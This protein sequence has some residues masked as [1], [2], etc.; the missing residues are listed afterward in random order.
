MGVKGL[1][2]LIK[3][4]CREV[5]AGGGNGESLDS[6]LEGQRRVV[7]VIDAMC[8]YVPSQKSGLALDQMS[9]GGRSPCP[10]VLDNFRTRIQA[11]LDGAPQA[12]LVVVFDGDKF[13]P[14]SATNDARIAHREKARAKL[15]AL[16][17][18]LEG[19]EV[20]D[21]IRTDILRLRRDCVYKRSDL[22]K[23]LVSW[24]NNQD[25][26]VA[27]QS[28]FEADAQVVYLERLF[29]AQGFAAYSVGIDSDIFAYGSDHFCIYAHKGCN[30]KYFN[31]VQ[32]QVVFQSHSFKHML[33]YPFNLFCALLGNDF[34]PNPTGVGQ[35]SLEK[36]FSTH[37]ADGY[38][39][40]NL[41]LKVLE[42]TREHLLQKK[43]LPLAEVEEYE[44]LVNR[45]V[46]IFACYPVFL[47]KPES[48][49]LF[50]C[51]KNGDIT[52]DIGTH[53]GTYGIDDEL[54]DLLQLNSW[55]DKVFVYMES[56]GADRAVF[57]KIFQADLEAT[58]FAPF[59]ESD[60][61]P[62]VTLGNLGQLPNSVLVLWL[63][64]RGIPLTQANAQNRDALLQIV[65]NALRIEQ[66]YA[67]T[68]HEPFTVRDPSELRV[69]EYT[70]VQVWK[71]VQKQPEWQSADAVCQF[72]VDSC[73]P[74]TFEFLQ[75]A[76]PDKY[77]RATYLYNNGHNL[78]KRSALALANRY[79]GRNR[80]D[81]TLTLV[82]IPVIPSF[83]SPAYSC[84]LCF[85]SNGC[86]KG[87]PFSKCSCKVGALE[88]AHVISSLMLFEFIRSFFLTNGGPVTLERLPLRRSVI[89]LQSDVLLAEFI[90]DFTNRSITQASLEDNQ[91]TTRY[92]QLYPYEDNDGDTDGSEADTDDTS[93]SEGE[94][95]FERYLQEGIRRD[96]KAAANFAK[97]RWY[98]L[99]FNQWNSLEKQKAREVLKKW[100]V[101]LS[102][103]EEEHF[104]SLPFLQAYLKHE[105][106][107]SDI[108][109]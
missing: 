19:I 103:F 34:C 4:V 73:Q 93:T 8:L 54:I 31:Y 107:K 100:A 80:C 68:D 98:Q 66:Q 41:S 24:C 74:P 13:P 95:E 38:E 43:K 28:P 62:Q 56:P 1:S 81:E 105:P 46:T 64:Y 78:I 88:C 37:A 11:L 20:T 17:S 58:T 83:N 16:L 33:G 23:Q 104:Q 22:T 55:V 9:L 90:P 109:Q 82:K 91:R 101:L 48:P 108:L 70:P 42:Q 14:K 51:L 87:V 12:K 85:N 57:A 65:G 76:Y 47:V 71:P 18:S 36:W 61:A 102:E 32:R 45:A 60:K 39:A 27:L 79:E 6:I 99:S 63:D 35:K 49:D 10:A 77:Q 2:K 5:R 40:E 92:R 84:I 25:R 69:D 53:D 96:K 75:T 21:A 7:L 97:V 30:G 26:V 15:E 106:W 50:A 29:R 52:V 72:I 94:G 86:F 44:D 59:P 89:A 3:A 67:E